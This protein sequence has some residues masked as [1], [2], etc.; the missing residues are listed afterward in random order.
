MGLFQMDVASILGVDECT[1]TNWEKNRVTPQPSYFPKIIEFLG[2]ELEIFSGETLGEKLKQYRKL[3]GINQEVFAR[4]LGIDPATLARWE[5]GES[6]L[7]GKM[8][9]KLSAI[10]AS[11]H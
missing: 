11:L 4:Q 1:V 5:S 7:R 8:R 6:E 10:F 2:Y 9:K 3:R